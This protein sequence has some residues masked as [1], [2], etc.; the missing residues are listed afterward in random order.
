MK[1]VYMFS[2]FKPFAKEIIVQLGIPD[3]QVISTQ[4]FEKENNYHDWLKD[5]FKNNEVE[6]ILIP[7]NLNTNDPI[8]DG[9]KIALHIRLN[10]ELPVIKRIVPIIFLSDFTL[11]VIIRNNDFDPFVNPQNLFFTQ[12]I[13]LSS[14]DPDEIKNLIKKVEPC[15]ENEYHFG[16]LNKLRIT[17]RAS[18]G[19][20]SISN[21]WGCFKLAQVTGLRDEIYKN[22]NIAEHLKTFY[23]KYL[24]CYNNAFTNEI[25]I[26]L[27]P[28][29]CQGKK[30]LLIDDQ[31][32]D[33]WSILM[34]NIFKSAGN[35]FQAIDSSNYK[36]NETKQFHDFEGF[37]A[38]CQ[39]QIGKDWDLI[40]M[41]L[42]LYPEKEDIDSEM[43]IPTEL[44]GYKL[45]EE[46]LNENE[47]YQIIVSTASNK[48]WNINTALKRGASSYYIKESPEFSY[49]IRETK[50]IYENF[51]YDVQ[52]CFAQ[53]Y[54]RIIYDDIK[55]IK[56]QL[57]GKAYPINFLNE[58]NSQ[59]DLAY[60][61]L[62]H[63]NSKVQFAYAFVTLY[64][65]IEAINN[66]FVSKVA[67]DKWDIVDTGHLLDWKWNSGAYSN[68]NTEVTGNKPP[69]WQKFAGVYIQKWLKTDNNF[70]Q[71]IYF[72]ITKRN[73]FV[74]NDNNILDKRDYAGN[75]LNHDI[76]EPSGFIKL[77]ECIKEISNSL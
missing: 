68:T 70:I 27:N 36:N 28:M 14:F 46:F 18:V 54:L 19:K 35:D 16:I 21:A 49:S 47:G 29:Q 60:E 34:K 2:D 65:F 66:Y 51:K 3:N 58:L 23:A 1:G 69:E 37:Y 44:S 13:F 6:K 33:G 8:N 15:G 50:G 7:L 26:D 45:I 38:E 75:Y 25:F 42:R 5:I 32:E 74:H 53:N 77:F 39:N 52:K 56:K 61:M 48:I 10:Y 20:H 55:T 57:A 30:I 22:E 31:A 4:T 62:D 11:D 12:S 24:I 9:L 17:Q 41:D 64:L 59:L 40:I 73:G 63:A 43:I 72:L 76:Y 67:D 71:T